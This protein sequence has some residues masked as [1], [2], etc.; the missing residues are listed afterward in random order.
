MPALLLL[1][2]LVLPPERQA[3]RRDAKLYWRENRCE[4]FGP[5]DCSVRE[6]RTANLR[7][8]FQGRTVRLLVRCKAAGCV[9]DEAELDEWIERARSQR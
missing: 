6:P 9:A 2:L 5:G 4:G 3:V 7:V 8:E 1:L